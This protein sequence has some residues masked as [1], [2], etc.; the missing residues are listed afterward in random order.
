MMNSMKQVSDMITLDR[1]ILTAFAVGIVFGVHIAYEIHVMFDSPQFDSCVDLAEY[2]DGIGYKSCV[3]YV[4][5]HPNAT[6]QDLVD[7]F[8]ATVKRSLD[9]VLTETLLP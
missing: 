5:E 3:E 4:N 6:G 8:D 1:I 2:A 9:D 7:H